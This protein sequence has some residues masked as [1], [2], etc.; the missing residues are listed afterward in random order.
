VSTVAMESKIY[1]RSRELSSTVNRIVPTCPGLV[2][3]ILVK[4]GLC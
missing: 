3:E 4:N 1:L 2:L